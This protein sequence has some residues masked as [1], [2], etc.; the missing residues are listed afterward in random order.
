M[1]GLPMAYW[2]I[3]CHVRSC[4]CFGA[5]GSVGVFPRLRASWSADLHDDDDDDDDDDAGD[6]DGDGDGC[7]RGVP[8]SQVVASCS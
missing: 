3:I 5:I 6:G 7:T 1:M 4:W 2:M 8:W